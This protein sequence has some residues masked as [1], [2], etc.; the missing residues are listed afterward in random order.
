M[1]KQTTEQQWRDR[2]RRQAV[3]GK[4]VLAFCLEEGVSHTHFYE[5]RKRLAQSAAEFVPISVSPQLPL[6]VPVPECRASALPDPEW[7]ARFLK[8]LATC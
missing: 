6:Q 2:I 7:L 1:T 5:R 8:A 3:S 4:T